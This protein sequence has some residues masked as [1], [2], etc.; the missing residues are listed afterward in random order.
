MTLSTKGFQIYAFLSKVIL[1][2][3]HFFSVFQSVLVF[4]YSA[5]LITMFLAYSEKLLASQLISSHLNTKHSK[6]L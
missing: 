5:M 3:T 6:Q 4:F 1:Y 2:F